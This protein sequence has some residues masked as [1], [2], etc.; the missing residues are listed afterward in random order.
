VL[1]EIFGL[2]KEDAMGLGIE[3]GFLTKSKVGQIVVILK[4]LMCVCVCVCIFRSSLK[5]K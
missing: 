2:M 4:L 3:Y 5:V 1:R